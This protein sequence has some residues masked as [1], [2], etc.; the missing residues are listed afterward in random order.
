MRSNRVNS[1]FR[2]K[3][4]PHRRVQR[5]RLFIQGLKLLRFDNTVSGFYAYFH[6]A[7]AETE[8]PINEFP[9]KILTPLFAPATSIS[10]KTNAFPL[11]SYVYLIY[12]MILCYYIA[13]PCD[14]DLWPFD[15]ES[16]S[17]TVL[18][19]SDPHTIYYYPTTETVTAHA[20]CHVIF[21]RGKNS[22]HFWN[23]WPQ[24]AYSLYNFHAATMTIKGSLYLSI[25]C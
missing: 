13:W 4:G 15:L 9:V 16:V 17:C 14:L 2:S 21:N 5:P 8:T 12:S 23:P 19:M 25:P 10:Y 6:R 22:R 24:F 1:C 3:N 11:P 7:C 18:L 20:P